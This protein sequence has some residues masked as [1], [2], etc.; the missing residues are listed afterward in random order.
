MTAYLR[1]DFDRLRNAVV[2]LLNA[3]NSKEEMRG[4]ELFLTT[5]KVSQQSATQ[6]L[7]LYD[8]TPSTLLYFVSLTVSYVIVLLQSK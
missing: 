4:A 3:E 1:T 8:I 7:N 5:M 2:G 6:P